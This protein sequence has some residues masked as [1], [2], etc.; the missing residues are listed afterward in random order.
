MVQPVQAAAIDH[1]EAVFHDMRF[2][3]AK[4]NPGVEDLQVDAHI[5]AQL[6]IGSQ[7]LLHI[8]IGRFSED[9]A[10]MCDNRRGDWNPFRLNVAAA[11]PDHP[12]EGGALALECISHLRGQPGVIARNHF[13]GFVFQ[14]RT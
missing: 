12:A 11:N 3:K 7:V 6:L 13:V 4:V 5:K 2:D 10:F 14:H 1:I 8:G 9:I